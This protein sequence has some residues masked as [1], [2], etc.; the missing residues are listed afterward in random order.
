MALLVRIFLL[1]FVELIWLVQG[2]GP[3]AVVV[4]LVAVSS[5]LALRSGRVREFVSRHPLVVLIDVIALLL[6]VAVVGVDSPFVL[7]LG[8]SA[9]V[10]GLWLPVVPGAVVISVL[11]A[12]HLTLLT[13]RSVDEAAVSAF[14]VLVPAVVLTL[15]LLGIA[16]Q[17]SGR[18]EARA[19][20]SLRDA[21]A[22]AAASEERGRIAREMHDTVAK[23][24]QAMA[25]TASALPAHLERRP[26]VAAV[27]ARELESDCTDVIGQVRA[28]MGEL[29]VPVAEVPF[30]ESVAQVVDE[31]RR[32]SPGRV[33]TRLHPVEVTDGLVR[34]EVL[35]G[36]REALENVRRHAGRCTTTVTLDA[37]GDQV[38]LVV[39]DD[40]VGSD[41]QQVRAAADSG[42]F[43]VVGMRE[44]MQRV[45]GEL[46]HD[47]VPG[48]GTTVRFR[49]HRHGLVEKNKGVA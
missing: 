28:L 22:V 16:I 18:A 48:V 10:V 38:V 39:A 19:Q 33:V 35:M 27:R 30:A 9:L 43:G 42:H 37:D 7:A 8:T 41:P 24:L 44:R 29:R 47:S 45:A 21:M 3:E 40:G 13:A 25:F 23:S 4:V 15:W 34:Y 6:V 26:E 11:L 36:L 49:V 46:T 32:T 17:R 31:W 12:V 20:A 1:L 14:V 5:Y 2:R